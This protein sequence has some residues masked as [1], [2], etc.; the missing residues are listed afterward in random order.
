[1]GQHLWLLHA[2]VRDQSDKSV[3]WC[4]AV[5][6]I[7]CTLHTELLLV[8]PYAARCGLTP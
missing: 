1:V 3:E 8:Q 5:A 2:C 7:E 6:R 4:V